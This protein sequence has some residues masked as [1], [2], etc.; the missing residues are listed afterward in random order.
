MAIAAK[1]QISWEE[2]DNLARDAMI[3]AMDV[4]FELGM[5]LEEPVCVYT[6]CNKLDV[7]V[8]F[9][10]VDMEG[11][12][13]P[14][15]KG[16]ILISSGR[17]FARR[18]FTCAHELGHHIF[19]H[20]ATLDE[21][22]DEANAFNFRHPNEFTADAF[23]GHFLM[24][25]IGI[26]NAVVRRSIDLHKIMPA[27]VYA[28]ATEFGVGYEALLTHLAFALKDITPN[29]RSE[30]LRSRKAFRSMFKS[31]V[32]GA[33]IVLVDSHFNSSILDV[34]V[35]HLIIAPEGAVSESD[36]IKPAGKS[37]F[38]PVFQATRR[39]TIR[40]EIPG[41]LETLTV[42]IAPNRF[43]GLAQFRHLEDEE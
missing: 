13:L 32:A 30:L 28:L 23:A 27:H 5:D 8:R 15:A 6:A 7:I 40:M 2:K 34:E 10:D 19:G 24:P 12:Y 22:R 35:N 18:H 20:G 39:G 17:P 16:R 41:M 42:R 9:V 4:R 43:V 11:V 1:H 29:Q 21:I 33:E 38:G 3:A 14:E 25:V 26:R 36:I 31:E 37:T